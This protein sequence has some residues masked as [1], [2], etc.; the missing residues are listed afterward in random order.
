MFDPNGN[1]TGTAGDG[2][3]TYTYDRINQLKTIVFSDNAPGVT[4]NYDAVGNRTSMVDGSGTATYVY[5]ALDRLKSLTRGTN[6][7]SYSYDVSGN[8][9]NRTYPDSTQIAYTYDEDNRLASVASGG[10]TTNYAYDPASNLTQTTLPVGNGYLETRSYDRAGHLTEV[11][12]AQGINTLS[13]FTSTLDPVGNPTRIVQSGAVASTTDYTYDANDRLKT[14]C[15]QA[16]TCPGASDPFIR[17]TYDKVG[18]RLTEA[19]PAPGGTTNYTYNGLDQLTQAGSTTYTY[20]QNGNEKTAG[21]RTFTYDLG[22]RLKTTTSGSTTTTTYTYDG[23]GNR[24]QASTGNQASKKTNFLWDTNRDLPQLAI[25]RD[26]NNALLRRY[27]YG[28]RRISMRSGSLDYYYHYDSL[29]SVRNVTSSAGVTQWTDT[30]EP[31]GAIR[32]ETKNVTTAPDNF[33][34]FTGEL[35]DSTGLYYLRARQYDPTLGR[36][37]RIDPVEACGTLPHTGGYVYVADRPTVLIDPSGATFEPSNAGEEFAW[38]STSMAPTDS[39]D[40]TSPLPSCRSRT[41]NLGGGV[42]LGVQFTPAH[43]LQWGFT[44]T[45]SLHAPFDA[46]AD[47]R[48]PGGLRVLQERFNYRK[49]LPH[50]KFSPGDFINRGRYVLEI[51]FYH[52]EHHQ[53]AWG[54]ISWDE[55]WTGEKKCQ[56]TIH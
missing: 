33:M 20:D 53:V 9:T 7:F 6:A 36:F 3:T 10:N 37:L 22:N 25:E 50:A 1:A 23:E 51:G 29:G 11:K 8:V 2:K 21:S 46:L 49:G 28:M 34:K 31:F 45:R 43:F 27:L 18:N 56:L 26:G 14:V 39:A 52:V 35:S 12:N 48:G 24:L 17:L 47:L 55:V 13:D 15:F 19:R 54:I 38:L 41:W 42:S 16:G 44:A 4:F 30:Y 5:D 40:S 32:T